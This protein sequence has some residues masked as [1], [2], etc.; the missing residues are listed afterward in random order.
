MKTQN[1]LL[2]LLVLTSLTACDL[3]GNILGS[4]NEKP[5]DEYIPSV[6]QKVFFQYEY[7]NYAW[8]YQHRGW[9]ID[10]E[11]RVC[12]FDQPLTRNHPDSLGIMADTAMYSNLLQA[13]SISIGVDTVD[14]YKYVG[15]I[16]E[17]AEGNLT[18]P[19]NRMCDAGCCTFVAYR[20]NPRTHN[21]R[22]ILLSQTG[23][24]Q[25]QNQSAAAD[26]ILVWLNHISQQI[27]DPALPIID[28][29]KQ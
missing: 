28:L 19:V 20:Y 11:G 12:R 26:S 29:P 25:I 8:G 4:D 15:L 23:D 18:K 10:S 22:S 14:L 3:L 24:W 1:I 7:I 27:Y 13:D 21:Y 2:T 6:D 9:I 17:A 16:N 5:I